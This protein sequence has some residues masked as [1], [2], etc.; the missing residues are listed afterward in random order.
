M[1]LRGI[2]KDSPAFIQ[3]A[4]LMGM[5]FFGFIF[6]SMLFYFIALAMGIPV[7]SV[8]TN[9]NSMRMM[10]FW[11]TLFTFLVPACLLAHLFSD[12]TNRYLQLRRPSPPSVALTVLTMILAIP[13]LNLTVHLNEQIVLPESMKS[14]ETILRNMED[15]AQTFTKQLLTTD[16]F[17]I[18]LFNI[19]IF[20]VL[21]G[22]GEEFFFRGVLQRIVAKTTANPHVVIWIVAFLF[23]VFHFQFYGL[24]PR[25]LLG[26]LMGYLLLWT[27]SIW[28]P[29][30]AHF[31]NN[32][33]GV[34]NFYFIPD[35]KDQ[36]KLD[37]LGLGNTLWLSFLSLFL[38]LST[39]WMIK[40]INRTRPA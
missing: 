13:F 4:I 33:L 27:R 29:V 40:K 3:L 38:V 8:A 20:A 21:A 16:S 37:T 9:I 31:T 26:A 19:V 35:A 7:E 34:L 5:L 14:L 25:M 2:F 1:N 39:I 22:I 15:T 17:S 12:D 18:F 32:L 11:L 36:E 30:T 24:I 28:V 10:Q 6:G 23:S